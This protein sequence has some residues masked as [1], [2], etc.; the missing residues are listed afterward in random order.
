MKC[1]VAVSGG[2]DS[3]YALLSLREMGYEVSALHALFLPSTPGKGPA[4]ALAGLCGELGIPFEAVDLTEEFRRSVIEPFAQAHAQARTPNPCALCNRAMKFGLLL[5]HALR[6]GGLYATGHYA[7]LEDHPVYGPALK[8]ASYAAKDQSYFLALVPVERL[9]S[10]LFPLADKTKPE[11]RSWLEERGYPIPLPSESQEICF[12]PND[13][14][15]AWLENQRESGLELPGDGPVVLAGE[16]RVIGRHRGL[17]QYTEGQRRGL[18]IAWKNPLYVVA[19]RRED[20]T[21][22]VGSKEMLHAE[23]CTVSDLNIMVPEHLWPGE[24]FLRVRYRHAPV[25]ADIILKEGRMLAHFHKAQEPPAP[26]QI[27][28]VYDGDGFLLAG[29]ILE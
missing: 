13:D 21:L 10:C 9:R 27:A 22:I 26:G 6:A 20:N 25:P 12:I 16:N 3:L 23:T 29:G 5:R 2:S 24:V 11:T 15:C 19:R 28:A 17:W 14:H 7:S 4:A 1:T 18:R 8:T